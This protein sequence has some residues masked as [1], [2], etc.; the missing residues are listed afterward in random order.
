[1]WYRGDDGEI[2]V[3]VLYLQNLTIINEDNQD[4]VSRTVFVGL[5]A[6]DPPRRGGTG[7]DRPL[8]V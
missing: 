7:D 2:Q 6:A 1:L 4:L 8:A 5:E 3:R